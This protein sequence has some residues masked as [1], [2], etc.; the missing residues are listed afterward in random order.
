MCM[1]HVFEGKYVCRAENYVNPLEAQCNA[2]WG[3]VYT[4]SATARKTH[5][6]SASRAAQD[7]KDKLPIARI[8]DSSYNVEAV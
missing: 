8:A 6:R 2:I 5:H 1:G 4:T 7:G 3:P